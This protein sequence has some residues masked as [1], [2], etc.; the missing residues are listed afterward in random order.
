MHR[1]MGLKLEEDNLNGD[2]SVESVASVDLMEALFDLFDADTKD[3]DYRGY[4]VPSS[5]IIQRLREIEDESKDCSLGQLWNS[6]QRK[7]TEYLKS[8]DF[9]NKK[10]FLFKLLQHQ[11]EDDTISASHFCGIL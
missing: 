8:F 5:V 1:M 3:I 2:R 10:T 9:E 11:L 4:T 7:A 6:Q